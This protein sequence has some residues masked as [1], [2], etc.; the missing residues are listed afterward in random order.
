MGAKRFI[1]FYQQQTEKMLNHFSSVEK[2]YRLYLNKSE[3]YKC[4]I[5]KL[6][7]SKEQENVLAAVSLKEKAELEKELKSALGQIEQL[8]E[9]LMIQKE[10]VLTE[11]KEIEDSISSSFGCSVEDIISSLA[12]CAFAPSSKLLI[13]SQIGDLAVKGFSTVSGASGAH[14]KKD[15][16]IKKLQYCSK[17]IKALVTSCKELKNGSLQMENKHG[18]LVLMNNDDILSLLRTLD[19]IFPDETVALKK[20][21]KKFT[22]MALEQNQKILDYNDLILMIEEKQTESDSHVANE[23]MLKI[24]VRAEVNPEIPQIMQYM[25]G[26]YQEAQRKVMFEIYKECRAFY[27]WSI[28]EIICVS[29]AFAKT[30]PCDISCAM[31]EELQN[32][33]ISEQSNIVES[34][35]I[36]PQGTIEKG[37]RIEYSLLEYKRKDLLEKMKYENSITFHM[38]AADGKTKLDDNPFAKKADVRILKMAVQV[39]GAK[40]DN[41]I[42]VDVFHFGDEI[43]YN[44]HGEQISF[45]HDAI[46]SCCEYPSEE[47]KN[48][49]M[50]YV[51]FD[52]E[53]HTYALVSPFA[54][55]TISLDKDRHKHLNLEQLED[56][57]LIFYVVCKSFSN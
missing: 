53:L 57:K 1:V 32:S 52:D 7:A 9:N 50:V 49:G 12:M 35:G 24:L 27:Y 46:R 28:N 30:L 45:S 42:C 47:T 17:D 16:L 11:L 3:S 22:D 13:G 44:T 39:V 41:A 8:E 2:E 34:R 51:Q 43:I 29:E 18:E 33:L 19:D 36:P 55:W 31:L 56:I 20:T 25:S 54:F 37:I 5:D 40:A 38:V 6:M 48:K 14:I 26:L 15:Y 10:A 4:K 23:N 21:F